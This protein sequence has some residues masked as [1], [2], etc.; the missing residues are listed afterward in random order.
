MT[1]AMP[2]PEQSAV[3]PPGPSRSGLRCPEVMELHDSAQVRAI[4]NLARARLLGVLCERLEASISQLAEAVD[5]NRGTVAYHMKVLSAAGLVRV[6]RTRQVRAIA[7][8]Y[9]AP[10]A[11]SFVLAGDLT[12]L[13]HGVS[14]IW[15]LLAEYGGPVSEATAPTVVRLRLPAGRAAQLAERI[16]ELVTEYQGDEDAGR[17]GVEVGFVCGAYRVAGA[18]PA[19]AS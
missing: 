3:A 9:Y 14:A 11:R 12:S 7:E 4:Q 5:C 2:P 19:A 13:H 10:V 1:A 17:A 8:R 6:S 15:D 16:N 18:R